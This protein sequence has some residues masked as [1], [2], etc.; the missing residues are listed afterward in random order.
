[1]KRKIIPDQKY[2]TYASFPLVA[3]DVRAYEIQLDLGEDVE[4]AEFKVT[5][6]R[7]DGEV[8]EDLGSVEGGICR[9]TIQNNMY[10]VP[11]E[12]TIRLAVVHNSSVLTDREIIFEVLSGSGATLEPSTAVTINDSVILRVSSLEEKLLLKVDKENGKGLSENDF[13]DDYK[14]KLDNL[15]CGVSSVNQKTGDVVIGKE[16][17]GLSNVDNTSDLDKP[18]SSAV[19]EALDLKADKKELAQKA[20]KSD[21]TNLYKFKGSVDTYDG[22]YS[23]TPILKEIPL[24]PA[25][26]PLHNGE[27]CG[28]FD[29]NTNAVTI[30]GDGEGG[31][32]YSAITVPVKSVTLEPGYYFLENHTYAGILLAYLQDDTCIDTYMCESIH[33]ENCVYSVIK[34]ESEAVVEYAELNQPFYGDD[35]THN[36]L[37]VL[38]KIAD[39]CVGEEYGDGYYPTTLTSVKNNVDVGDTYNVLDTDMNYAWNG[40][41]WDALGGKHIDQEA[42]DGIFNLNEAVGELAVAK[43]DVAYV[44]GRVNEESELLRNDIDNKAN[45]N[46]VSNALK[47][48]AS[49]EVISLNDVS[50]VGHTLD[51]RVSNENIIPYPYYYFGNQPTKTISGITF[52]DNGDGSITINGTSEVFVPFYLT[53]YNGNINDLFEDGETYTMSKIPTG[54]AMTLAAYDNVNNEY[55]YYNKGNSKTTFTIDK[56]TYDYKWIQLQIEAN[57]TIDNQTIYPKINKGTTAAEYTPYIEDLTGVKLTVSESGEVYTSNLDGTVDGVQSISPNM[58]LVTDA[59][60]VAIDCK[61]NKDANKVIE[62]LTNAIIS[63]GGNV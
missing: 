23:V 26:K 33:E 3:G 4:N 52:T 54:V 56:S 51:I 58:T 9:Y 50:P 14:Q 30:Y 12:L 53:L 60:G 5:A 2:T 38:Y 8:V 36:Y 42:R 32:S 47:G 6:F 15:V 1:M 25:G 27:G 61:Y 11:G 59:E 43:A 17:V 49:G 34:I 16:D 18:M 10:S 28:S 39:V 62:T 24:I 35:K 21:I 48:S 55:S 40:E 7:S 57:V 22:L 44:D 45:L 19:Q 20:D 13:T 31:T 41:A 29:E 46:E 63:L 37:G